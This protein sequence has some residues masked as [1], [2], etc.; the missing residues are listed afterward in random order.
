[1]RHG[2]LMVR[3]FETETDRTLCTILDA[4]R[5]MAFRSKQAP[6][7]KLAYCA[8]ITAA[9]SKVALAA[10]DPI[11]IDWLG[12]QNRP[13]KPSA[14]R[15]TFERAVATLEA[16]QAD[17]TP[18]DVELG[19]AIARVSR[20]TPRGAVI[21]LMS[22]LIDLPEQAAEVITALSTRDRSVLVLR[23]LDPVEADFPFDEPVR[24]RAA[25]GRAV[26]ETDGTLARRGYLDALE[27]LTKSWEDQ[28]LPRGGHLIR[29]TTSQDPVAVVRELL[30]ALGRSRT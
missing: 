18:N 1:M 13:L 17:G 24:L 8:L 2:K 20:V 5:S 29:A 25:E 7:A 16:A 15:D 22:D 6:A 26:V 4:S 11:G 21:V 3:Q 23:V 27:V 19:R 12:A 9:L 30:L 10:G 14:G 28:L